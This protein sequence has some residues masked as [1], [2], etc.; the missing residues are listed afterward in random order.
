MKLFLTLNK[1]VHVLTEDIPVAPYGSSEKNGKNSADSDGIA[2]ID[3]S[4]KRN[5]L[6]A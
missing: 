5:R 1:V 2:K 3:E 4:A 6:M